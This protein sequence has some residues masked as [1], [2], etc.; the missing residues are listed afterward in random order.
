MID[1]LPIGTRYCDVLDQIRGGT[2]ESIQM[3][4]PIA[5]NFITARVVFTHERGAVGLFQV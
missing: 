5:T 2:L 1:Y 4:P 3:Y